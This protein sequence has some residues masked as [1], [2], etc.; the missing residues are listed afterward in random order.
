MITIR[1]ATAAAWLGLL[2]FGALAQ[3]A[4]PPSPGPAGHAALAKGF[5][6]GH[7]NLTAPDGTVVDSDDLTGKPYG[8][9]FGFTHCPDVCPTTLAELSTALGKLPTSDLKIYFITVDPERDTPEV[10]TQYMTSFD[11]RIV[12]LTGTRASVEAAMAN[13]GAIAQRVDQPGGG[14]AYGHTAAIL[15]VNGDGLITRRIAVDA[16]PEKIAEALTAL[17]K[18][19]ADPARPAEPSR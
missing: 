4:A 9:F 10:L 17:A 5:I 6:A 15:L 16:G 2:G 3:E 12:A 1:I 8:L 19:P 7:F 18:P 13:F 14:Y 11:P